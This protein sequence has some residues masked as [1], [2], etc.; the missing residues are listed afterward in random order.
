MKYNKRKYGLT[1]NWLPL[2]IS[3]KGIT[4]NFMMSTKIVHLARTILTLALNR[5]TKLEAGPH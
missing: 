2:F 5:M 3:S 1:C 4:R